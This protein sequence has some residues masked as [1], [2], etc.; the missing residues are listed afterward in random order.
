MSEEQVEQAPQPNPESRQDNPHP[1]RIKKSKK[2]LIIPIVILLIIIAIAAF[3]FF[4]PFS[5]NDKENDKN[6]D[7]IEITLDSSLEEELSSP[8]QAPTP[9]PIDKSEISIEVLNATGIAGQAASLKEKL[10]N[11]DFTQIETGNA[12]DDEQE[13][14]SVSF[15]STVD[16]QVRE[17]ILEALEDTYKEV[18][19]SNDEPQNSDILIIA[20][21]KVGQSLP[22]PEPTAPPES[23]SEATESA[24]E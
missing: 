10:E 17:E 4:E 8:T 3:L 23:D 9:E 15:S 19:I 2:V 12:D 11:L 20:G 18:I 1:T 16:E 5:D 6:P 13:S 24:Q 14:T 21:L 22:T 7:K